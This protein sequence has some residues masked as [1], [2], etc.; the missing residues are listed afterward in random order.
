MSEFGSDRLPKAC[1]VEHSEVV[2]VAM[3]PVGGLQIR[4]RGIEDSFHAAARNGIG[5]T[6]ENLA[7]VKENCTDGRHRD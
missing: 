1:A 6:A 5:W 4:M 7:E 3:A 2:V